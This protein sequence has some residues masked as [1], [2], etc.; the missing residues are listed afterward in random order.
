MQPTTPFGSRD[1]LMAASAG[2]QAVSASAAAEGQ[3]GGA[4][5]T[6]WSTSAARSPLQRTV[7]AASACEPLQS[8]CSNG[9]GAAGRKMELSGLNSSGSSIKLVHDALNSPS[10]SIKSGDSGG[11]GDISRKGITLV[12]CVVYSHGIMI[13][14]CSIVAP[15]GM[16]I[17]YT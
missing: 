13:E 5:S 16:F 4:G 9:G 6:T 10:G 7:S 3:A 12:C 15:L 17:L 2:N 1:D 11:G 14:H 8:H